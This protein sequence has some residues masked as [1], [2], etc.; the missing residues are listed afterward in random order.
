[1]NNLGTYF[2]LSAAATFIVGYTLT[3][4]VSVVAGVGAISPV[5]P[6]V[7]HHKLIFNILVTL[8][9]MAI[10]LRGTG[11]SA[12][13]F[14][15]FTYLFVFSIVALGFTAIIQSITHPNSIHIPTAAGI[16]AVQR[17]SLFLFYLSSSNILSTSDFIFIKSSLTSI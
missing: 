3:V 12:S 16:H 7:G 2:G 10:N 17:M 11:E 14:V 15:P 1:M 6:I 13:I 8:L 9:I 5:L 4:A